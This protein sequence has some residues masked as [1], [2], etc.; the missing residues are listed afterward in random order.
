MAGGPRRS[1][2]TP[3]LVPTG[4]SKVSIMFEQPLYL[5]YQFHFAFIA[6]TFI[7]LKRDQQF[8]EQVH[9]R[10]SLLI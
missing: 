10:N 1:P 2:M 6:M 4:F 3:V 7:F 5:F 8:C 9:R